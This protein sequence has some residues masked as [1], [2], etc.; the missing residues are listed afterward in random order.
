MWTLRFVVSVIF[1]LALSGLIAWLVFI[2]S[3]RPPK[4]TIDDEPEGNAH[5]G[6]AGENNPAGPSPDFV[7]LINAIR[8][9]AH[10]NRRE[11]RRED[12][13]KRRRGKL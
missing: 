11:A 2:C 1:T 4:D 12:R 10:A 3:Q 6:E 13:G 8:D 5:K 9:E 7:A